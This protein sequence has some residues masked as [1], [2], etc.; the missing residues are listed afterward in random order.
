MQGAE[1]EGTGSV[2]TYVTEPESRKQ[3]RRSPSCN[4]LIKAHFLSYVDREE[5]AL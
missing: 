4:S 3:R 2:L 1:G 5:C